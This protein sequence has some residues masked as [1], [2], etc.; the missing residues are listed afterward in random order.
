[1]EGH[2]FSDFHPSPPASMGTTQ[3]RG[4]ASSIHPSLLAPLGKT[5][6]SQNKNL[7]ICFPSTQP[8][9][10]YQTPSTISSKGLPAPRNWV[11]LPDSPLP[12]VPF[13]TGILYIIPY[14]NS[15][16]PIRL[17]APW[18][19]TSPTLFLFVSPAPST[20]PASSRCLVSN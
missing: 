3:H 5:S 12:Q 8:L 9:L 7:V 18:D 6:F 10:Y 11:K 13:E 4:L 15:I 20:V 1:M 16:V 17:P 19:R 2:V 14:Q